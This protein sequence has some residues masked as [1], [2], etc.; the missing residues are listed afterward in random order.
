MESATLAKFLMDL[1][2]RSTKPSVRQTV[3]KKDVSA[4]AAAGVVDA[5]VSDDVEAPKLIISL[6]DMT[7]HGGDGDG[8][9]KVF[10]DGKRH[11]LA[12]AKWSE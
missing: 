5:G 10:G 11:L 4:V 1:V 8:V 6:D 3:S 12:S 7:K 2:F 9:G